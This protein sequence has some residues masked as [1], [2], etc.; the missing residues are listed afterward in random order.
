MPMVQ[1]KEGKNEHKLTSK[2]NLQ[3]ET[4]K[5]SAPPFNKPATRGDDL[6]MLTY[7][8]NVLQRRI[9]L[10]RTIYTSDGL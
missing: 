9:D 2:V 7:M 6:R 1:Q 10:Y 3:F 4:L 8:Y 5:F